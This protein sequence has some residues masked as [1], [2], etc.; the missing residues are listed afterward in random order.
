MRQIFNIMFGVRA[1]CL[2]YQGST[3]MVLNIQKL[4]YNVHVFG[5]QRLFALYMVKTQLKSKANKEMA[6]M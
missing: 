6:A 5:K 4:F 1:H 2:M 3:F